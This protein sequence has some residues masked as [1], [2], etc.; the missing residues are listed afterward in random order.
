MGRVL[1]IAG[2][3]IV[4]LAIVGGALVYRTLNAAG[5]FNRV[6]S[7]F[8]GKCVAVTGVVGAEDIELDRQT[9]EL[10]ISSQDRR[11]FRPDGDRFRQGDIFLAHIDQLDSKPES[12]TAM[13]SWTLHPHGISLYKDGNGKRTLAVVN[14][15][16]PGASEIM[17][18]DVVEG[19]GK[20]PQLSLRRRVN[21]PLIHDAND[22]TLVGHDSFYVT[23]D[24]GSESQL[25]KTLETW[26]LLPRA[27]VVYFDG[28]AAK[29]VA[30][31]LNYANGINRSADLATIYV[32]ESTGRTL[33]IF[34]R[35]TTSGVLSP[36]RS[37]FLG[38][39]ADNID[40]DADGNLWIGAHPRM[41]DFLAHARDAKNLS[42][43]VVLKIDP[44]TDDGAARTI[45]ANTGEEASGG[46]VAVSNGKRMVI[47][48]VFEPK[49][50]NCTLAP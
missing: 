47:G 21:D 50:L 34:H 30:T 27:N 18:F 5:Y 11:P 16:T 10:F 15:V 46:S 19:A 33:D 35:D 44:T 28:N 1:R 25:G 24:H 17:L 23:N 32:A 42:P 8:A 37:L 14:H 6:V 2:V 7:A 49:V 4:V 13:M 29:V 39:G 45:Y 26:L 38:V 20:H 31:G 41:L 43:S 48:M 40:I 12:L 36:V 9:G 22:V 3:T